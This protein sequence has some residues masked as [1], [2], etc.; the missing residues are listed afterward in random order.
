[1]QADAL[2][3]GGVLKILAKS[4]PRTPGDGDLL[5]VTQLANM[6][7]EMLKGYAL[8]QAIDNADQLSGLPEG[9]DLYSSDRREIVT[10]H[11][12]NLWATSDDGVLFAY[13]EE[14]VISEFGGLFTVNVPRDE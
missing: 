12:K 10:K 2:T 8:V 9:T 3:A 5:W 14:E 13:T 7:D 4:T 1:M 11:E 6:L